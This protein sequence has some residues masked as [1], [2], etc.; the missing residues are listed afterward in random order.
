VAGRLVPGTLWLGPAAWGA[1]S[2]PLAA[3]A[4]APGPGATGALAEVAPWCAHGAAWDY[5]VV[6]AEPT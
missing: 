1:C 5:L 6:V 2:E 4:A 3:R